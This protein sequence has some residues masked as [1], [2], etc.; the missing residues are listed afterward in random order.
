M[1]AGIREIILND[2]TSKK[3]YKFPSNRVL[4]TKFTWIT[5]WPYFAKN[6]LCRPV[7][8]FFFLIIFAQVGRRY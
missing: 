3:A 2:Q 6:E 1:T 7:N 5:F 4:T 8:L